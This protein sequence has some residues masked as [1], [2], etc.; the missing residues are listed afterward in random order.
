MLERSIQVVSF[1][2]PRV[3]TRIEAYYQY[4]S[5]LHLA[6]CAHGNKENKGNKE[7][8][9]EKW[10]STLEKSSDTAQGCVAASGTSFEFAL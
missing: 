7:M 8:G 5:M 3:V 9:V 2:V 4:G 10:L 6:G 1:A